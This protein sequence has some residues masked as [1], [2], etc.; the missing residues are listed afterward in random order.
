MV[1]GVLFT[2]V[3]GTYAGMI[4]LSLI[5]GNVGWHW[6]TEG[7]HRLEHA[8]SAGFPSASTVACWVALAVVVGAGGAI[9]AEPVRGPADPTS[10]ERAARSW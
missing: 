4:V 1:L 7:A 8:V 6:M 5:I 3:L 10:P 9:P 2:H